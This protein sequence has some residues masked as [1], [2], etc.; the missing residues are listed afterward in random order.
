MASII[1]ITDFSDPVLDV[2]ARTPEVQL[3]RYR[4]P[5][6]GI[7]YRGESESD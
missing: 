5:K 6:P 1:P 3:L 4:E 2:Y 7:F